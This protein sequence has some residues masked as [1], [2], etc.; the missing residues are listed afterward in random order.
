MQL[1]SRLV[2]WILPIRLMIRSRYGGLKRRTAFI[3]IFPTLAVLWSKRIPSIVRDRLLMEEIM[4][5]EQI[6]WRMR[7]NRMAD[8]SFGA[9]L[10]IT[11][12]RTGGTALRIVRGRLMITLSRWMASSGIMYSCKSRTDRW[13]SRFGS[14]CLHCSERCSAPIR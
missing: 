5:M 9:A 2:E 10:S 13:I 3:G 4:P 14:Q 12:C 1:R 11:A 8:L 7:L 6:C